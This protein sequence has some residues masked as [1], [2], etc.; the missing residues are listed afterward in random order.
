MDIDLMI[1]KAR[2]DAFENL[3]F[4]YLKAQLAQNQSYGNKILFYQFYIENLKQ[5]LID[6]P[7]QSVTLR[8]RKKIESLVNSLYKAMTDLEFD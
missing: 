7:A 1:L 8:D 2:V 6:M 3:I 4:G 5:G